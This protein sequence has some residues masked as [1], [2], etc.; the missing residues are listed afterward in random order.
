MRK[1]FKFEIHELVNFYVQGAYRE[2][3]ILC[4]GEYTEDGLRGSLA[5]GIRIKYYVR[6][7]NKNNEYEYDLVTEDYLSKLED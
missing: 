3:L 5:H 7:L 2:A 1:L 6:F 4:R